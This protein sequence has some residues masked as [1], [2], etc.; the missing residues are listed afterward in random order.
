MTRD[1]LTTLFDFHYWAR[2]RMLEAVERLSPEQFVKPLGGSFAS[3]RQ[4]LVHMYSA[5]WIWHSRWYGVSPTEPLDEARFDNLASVVKAWRELEE[6]M[7]QML[8]E[9][10]LADLDASLEYRLLSGTTGRSVFWQMAQ[11][12]V[13]HGTYHRG[14]VTTLLRQ[15]GVAPPASTDLITYYR[16]HAS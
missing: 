7:R 3:V 2:D 13:N 4:T 11:H 14:Q 1:E 15:L 16:E 10:P 12:V 8:A 5:E 9:M 6:R